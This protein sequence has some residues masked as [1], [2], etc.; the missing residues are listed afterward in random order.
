LK[1]DDFPEE[2]LTASLLASIQLE[3]DPYHIAIR[4]AARILVAQGNGTSLY[5]SSNNTHTFWILNGRY[6]TIEKAIL[7]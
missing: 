7:G 5:A 2:K 3:K 4:N 1:I 6:I